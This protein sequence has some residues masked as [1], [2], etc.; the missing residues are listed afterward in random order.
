M[1]LSMQYITTLHP[2]EYDTNGP[3]TCTYQKFPMHTS[4]PPMLTSCTHVEKELRGKAAF[5]A[6]DTST[7]V[8]TTL[9]LSNISL[10]KSACAP[11]LVQ[12]GPTQP[13]GTVT[14]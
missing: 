6:L 13:V 9:A 10:R 1:R 12:F 4:A 8:R 2:V 7:Y 11:V 3:N 14:R 5:D